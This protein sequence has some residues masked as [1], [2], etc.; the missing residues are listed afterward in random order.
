MKR[1][2]MTTNYGTSFHISIFIM[3]IFGSCAK[4]HVKKSVDGYEYAIV[5]PGK[6]KEVQLGDYLIFNASLKQNNSEYELL[7][8]SNNPFNMQLLKDNSDKGEML[9]IVAN[10]LKNSRIGDSVEVYFPYTYFDDIPTDYFDTLSPVTYHVGILNIM[11][12]AQFSNYIAS[13]ETKK[14]SNQVE[15]QEEETLYTSHNNQDGNNDVMRSSN[16]NEQEYDQS[17]SSNMRQQSNTNMKLMGEWYYKITLGGMSATEKL[18]INKD[19]TWSLVVNNNNQTYYQ[20][21][22]WNDE[23][24]LWL[25][26]NDQYPWKTG[27]IGNDLYGDALLLQVKNGFEVKAYRRSLEVFQ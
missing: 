20:Y 15:S 23:I 19:G 6:G 26:G 8:T 5:R 3:I 7:E 21:G 18:I 25:D 27:R 9:N 13:Q 14:E 22:T 2:K 11:D 4:S 17:G 10:V 1:T 16:E 12:E 24:E